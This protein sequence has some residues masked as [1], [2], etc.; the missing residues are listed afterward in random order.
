MLFYEIPIKNKGETYKAIT[1]LVR[2]DNFSTG[3][4]SNYKYFSTLYKIIVI[5]LSK[6]KPE[7]KNQQINFISK[8]E[9]DATIFFI[10]EEKHTNGLEFFAKF[11]VYCIKM[12]S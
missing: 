8:L 3:K 10:I 2:N 9:Q 12:E 1:E 7:F 6:E 11:F 4:I 5:D